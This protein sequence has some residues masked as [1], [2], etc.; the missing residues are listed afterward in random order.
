M[1]G[2]VA[3]KEYVLKHL[4]VYDVKALKKYGQNFLVDD[5]LAKEI[6]DSISD[7]ENKTL[8]EIGPGLG[9][10]TYHLLNKQGKK[11]LVEIDKVMAEHLSR[12]INDENIDIVCQDFLK[13]NLENIQ[14]EIVV[15]ANL[16]YYVT[17]E[18]VE[19]LIKCPKVTQM[20]LMVQKEAYQRLVAP[21]NT[22]EYSPLSIFIEYL[23]GAKV[24]KKVSRHSYIPEPHVDSLVFQINVNKRKQSN[25]EQDFYKITKAMFLMRRKTIL[26]NLTSYVKDKDKAISL[27]KVLNCNENMR[28]EQLDLDFYLRLT[29]LIKR[30]NG[31][32]T[33]R[34]E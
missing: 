18:I 24:L 26:N 23:G 32:M 25:N 19:K 33:F 3:N 4:N 13:Y 22:K 12:Q 29:D 15:L 20:T 9:A 1:I 8:I 14:G 27:L 2:P 5:K 28:P 16:P 31:S 30:D 21:I 6:V 34:V 7:G 11:I 10:L 17:T